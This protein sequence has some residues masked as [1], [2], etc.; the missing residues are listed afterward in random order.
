M[1]FDIR[2]MQVNVKVRRA[3]AL[4]TIL[5]NSFFGE[6]RDG[7]QIILIKR[8]DVEV[9]LDTCGC[10]GFRDDRAPTSDVPTEEDIGW[11]YVL[12]FSKGFDLRLLQEWP[13][14]TSQGAVCGYQ[15]AL[16]LAICED[17]ILREEWMKL[18]LVDGRDFEILLA[19]VLQ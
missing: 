2:E 4:G 10:N 8:N 14:G 5:C 11:G 15:N 13:T 19:A 12:L 9:S 6:V 18:N 7:F 1:G 16:I 17:I 3:C